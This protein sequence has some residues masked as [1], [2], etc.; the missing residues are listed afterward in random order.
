MCKTFYQR[1]SVIQMLPSN[2]YFP[3]SLLLVLFLGFTLSMTK[4]PSLALLLSP[5]NVEIS[6][7]M[8][9]SLAFASSWQS[10]MT[11]STQMTHKFLDLSP[12]LKFSSMFPIAYST[13][14]P[15]CGTSTTNASFKTTVCVND[16][17]IFQNIQA[18]MTSGTSA[19]FLST[20]SLELHT[21]S[22]IK[23]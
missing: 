15:R 21:S 10:S 3:Y 11:L 8:C 6:L 2:M 18:N 1:K 14:L 22:G 17:T 23:F 19:S 13:F 16:I 9:L 12:F 7:R 5:L 4:F 20:L